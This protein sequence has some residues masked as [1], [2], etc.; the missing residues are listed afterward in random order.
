MLVTVRH[1]VE[2]ALT[3]DD[4]LLG[5]QQVAD[6]FLLHVGEIFFEVICKGKCNYRKTS[7]VGCA[8]LSLV[9][10]LL[11][12]LEFE[13]SLLAMNVTN[14]AEP[15]GVFQSSA[16]QASVGECVLHNATEAI[17]S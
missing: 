9:V 4:V 2:V 11:A 14:T 16:Q 8:V 3:R 15:A 13:I 7:I 1:T 12:L 6:R 5:A 10:L 17:E